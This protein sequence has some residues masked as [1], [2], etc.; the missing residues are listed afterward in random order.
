MLGELV[1]HDYLET[2]TQ[3]YCENHLAVLEEMAHKFGKNI[4]YQVAYNKPFEGERCGLYVGIPENEALGRPCVDYQ[5]LM[6]AAAHLGEK[7]RYSFECAAEFGHSYGQDYEDLFWW[8]K[9]S[10]MA[11]MNA[12]VLHWA[13]YS[14]AYKGVISWIHFRH[15]KNCP[16]YDLKKSIENRGIFCE[17]KYNETKS[18]TSGKPKDTGKERKKDK[19][20]NEKNVRKSKLNKQQRLL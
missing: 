4:R 11:G 10:L 8:V 18:K 20:G 16:G 2:L 5:K 17:N 19:K 1:N 6:A 13:S 15:Y 9:R 7:E 3:C 12:Q 14:G